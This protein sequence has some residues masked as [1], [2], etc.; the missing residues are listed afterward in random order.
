MNLV[1]IISG[2]ILVGLL[3]TTLAFADCGK[4]E[5]GEEHT[6]DKEHSHAVGEKTVV[7]VA[8][9]DAQFSTLVGLLKE[10]GLVETLNGDGPFTVFAPT[11]DAFAK[12]PAE[13]L[14]GLKKDKEKLKQVLTYHVVG[15]MVKGADAAKLTES[16][17]VSGTDI[18]ISQKGKSL[19]INDATVVKADI[20]ASNG[21]VHVVDTV[22]IPN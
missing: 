4:C 11:N 20:L 21:V 15:G 2:S 17:T 16:K 8:T 6:H 13:T 9:S 10:A 7:G 12:I 22:L 5:S 14:A 18:A 3:S 19:M 1:K